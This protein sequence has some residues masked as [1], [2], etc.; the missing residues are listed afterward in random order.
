M[1]SR[2]VNLPGVWYLGESISPEYDIPASQSPLGIIYSGKS[3]VKICFEIS[4]GYDTP[5]K[6]T[7][8]YILLRGNWL[9]GCHI[10]R[11][12][13]IFR[14]VTPRGVTHDPGIQQ[15]FLKTFAQSFKGIVSQ[16]INVVS[17]STIKGLHFVFLQTLSYMTFFLLPRVWYPRELVFLL[18]KFE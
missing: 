7:R 13:W 16:K 2:R 12:F 11:R 15:P 10:P 6:L 4:S 18:Q 8:R 9:T 14:Y 5:R 17:Y 3:I 1:I